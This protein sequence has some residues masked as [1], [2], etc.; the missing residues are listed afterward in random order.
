MEIKSALIVAKSTPDIAKKR[1]SPFGQRYR[2]SIAMPGAAAKLQKRLLGTQKL[3]ADQKIWI[4]AHLLTFGN[5]YQKR[6]K[7]PA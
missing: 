5:L 6:G 2:K 7:I 4:Y 1:T 3:P